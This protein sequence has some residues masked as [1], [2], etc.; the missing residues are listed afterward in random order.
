L[1]ATNSNGDFFIQF[2]KVPFTVATAEDVGGSWQIQFGEHDYHRGG[3]GKPPSRFVWFE[4]P[5]ALAGATDR[6]WKFEREADG[7]WR[8]VDSHAGETLEGRFFP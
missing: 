5:R 3:R 7:Q 2:S 4:L 6:R 8:L 1:F